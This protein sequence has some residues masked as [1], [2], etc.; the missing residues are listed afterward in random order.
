MAYFRQH[1]F[2]LYSLFNIGLLTSSGLHI[3]TYKYQK[4]KLK[5]MLTTTKLGDFIYFL[6]RIYLWVNTHEVSYVLHMLCN[7]KSK[8]KSVV[9]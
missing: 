9:T 6:K 5:I 1:N 3:C 2:K 8:Y 4:E 7:R